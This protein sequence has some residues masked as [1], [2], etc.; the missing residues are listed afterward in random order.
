MLFGLAAVTAAFYFFFGSM[1]YKLDWITE[2]LAPPYSAP[3]VAG[4]A[5]K[6]NGNEPKSAWT[7][8][9]DNLEAG[10]QKAKEE[11]KRAFINFTGV[12]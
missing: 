8:V 5:G 2:T 12:T 7:R 1:G 11:K 9:D 6:D 10:L 4:A 3:R